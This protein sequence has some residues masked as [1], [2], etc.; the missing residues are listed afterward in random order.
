MRESIQ[1]FENLEDCRR[2]S[3]RIAV[4]KPEHKEILYK[5]SSDGIHTTRELLQ[6]HLERPAN[7]VSWILCHDSGTT[8]FSHRQ[9]TNCLLEH[10]SRDKISEYDEIIV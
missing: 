6:E 7:H 2:T 5:R 1:R 9:Y 4:V 8:H 10:A 3:R